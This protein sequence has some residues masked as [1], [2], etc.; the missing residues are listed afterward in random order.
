[1]KK[2]RL[3]KGRPQQKDEKVRRIKRNIKNEDKNEEKKRKNEIK[4]R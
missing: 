4:Q 1:M 2:G 3:R